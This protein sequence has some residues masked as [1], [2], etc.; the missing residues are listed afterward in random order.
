VRIS[1]AYFFAVK[2]SSFTFFPPVNNFFFKPARMSNIE[3]MS[4]ARVARILRHLQPKPIG[5]L[6]SELA[7]NETCGIVAFTSK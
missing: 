7:S 6:L 3:E 2:I 4:S 5:Q 1:F